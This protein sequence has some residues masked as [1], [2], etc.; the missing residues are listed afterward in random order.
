MDP[1]DSSFQVLKVHEVPSLDR[2]TSHPTS[3][4]K[5]KHQTFPW[6]GLAPDRIFKSAVVTPPHASFERLS[7]VGH[8]RGLQGW[9]VLKRYLA[10]AWPGGHAPAHTFASRSNKS[11]FS[12][13]GSATPLAHRF[14]GFFHKK[15]GFLQGRGVENKKCVTMRVSAVSQNTVYGLDQDLPASPWPGPGSRSQA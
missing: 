7:Q 5:N 13:G 9:E 6:R 14:F 12:A 2:L 11:P 8:F 3:S 15:N 10:K 4:S 1:S